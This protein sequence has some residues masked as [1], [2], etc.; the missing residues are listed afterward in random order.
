[1]KV[2]E[3]SIIDAIRSN[4]KDKTLDYLK[5]TLTFLPGAIAGFK[6]E[7]NVSGTRGYA[8]SCSSNFAKTF[9]TAKYNIKDT[10][11]PIVYGRYVE[12]FTVNRDLKGK[13]NN[14][15]LASNAA[16]SLSEGIIATFIN[17]DKGNNLAKKVQWWMDFK[18]NK[19]SMVRA[20]LF[21]ATVGCLALCLYQSIRDGSVGKYS[22]LSTVALGSA[23][24][25]LPLFVEVRKDGAFS[26]LREYFRNEVQV[27]AD[28]IY[29]KSDLAKELA[30]DSQKQGNAL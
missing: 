20:C 10:I 12:L 28:D 11:F 22:F 21:A 14:I 16:L 17:S 23:I 7:P 27:Y 15:D 30:K 24:F 29:S 6:I 18:E 19:L 5:D 13:V 9:I 3:S 2:H 26:S 8:L 1:M 4:Y 25:G